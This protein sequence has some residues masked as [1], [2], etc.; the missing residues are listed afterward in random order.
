M[1]LRLVGTRSRAIRRGTSREGAN[2]KA[3]EA[4]GKEPQRAFA[5][6]AKEPSRH[7][8]PDAPERIPTVA[9]GV[10]RSYHF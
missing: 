6:A 8:A 5:E 10:A 4:D 1:P 9:G 7:T 3:G 2:V